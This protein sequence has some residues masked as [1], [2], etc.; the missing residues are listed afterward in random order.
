[1]NQEIN[2]SRYFNIFLT[3]SYQ[4]P[5]LFD[6]IRFCKHLN[7]NEIQKIINTSIDEIKRI[8]NE[9]IN[10]FISKNTKF[11]HLYIPYQFDF[12]IHLIP[13]AKTCFSE[14]KF[15]SC[16]TSINDN[17]VAKL[18]DICKSIK[19]LELIVKVRNNN[20]G[21]IKLIETQK[22][23]FNLRLLAT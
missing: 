22:Q 4:K 15:L 10:L 2:L 12:Q 16:N 14:I 17:I 7:L 3:N 11:T 5:L 20:Y 13:E 23:L 19:E 8:R 9:V 1:M 21:I 18:T 6:Y